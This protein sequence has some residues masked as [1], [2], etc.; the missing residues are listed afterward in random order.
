MINF[1]TNKDVTRTSQPL[2]KQEPDLVLP[3][4]QVDQQDTKNV[5]QEVDHADVCTCI[6]QLCGEQYTCPDRNDFDG[7]IH[8][9]KQSGFKGSEAEGGDDDL[10]LVRER[11]RD[12]VDRAEEREEPRLGVGKG[13]TEPAQHMALSL[14]HVGGR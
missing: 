11:V 14:V 1:Q 7:T 13:L 3:G 2:S 9:T 4:Q 8:A 10:A 6:F 12:V 5:G